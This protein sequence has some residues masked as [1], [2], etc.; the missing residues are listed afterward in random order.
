MIFEERKAGVLLPVFSLPSAYGIGTFGTQAYR[1]VDLLH[2]AKQ[3]Y[4]QVLPQGAT[5]YRDSPYQ[6]F[7][8]F[9]GNPYFIDL[10]L[11][12]EKGVITKADCDS[13]F[14]GDDEN[15]ID[16]KAMY[17]NRYKLLRIA[18]AND[19][20]RQSKEYIEFK[21]QSDFWLSDYA[22][23][24]AVK[25][26]NNGSPWYLWQ[27]AERLKQPFCMENLHRELSE[28]IEFYKYLQYLF[29]AQWRALKSYANQKGIQIIGDIPIYVALDSADVWADKNLF[30][31]DD[32]GLPTMVAGCPP[33]GFSATGQLWGNPLYNWQQHQ[34]TNFAWWIKRVEQTFQMYDVVRIDH[35]RGF[36][37][38]YA[39]PFGNS[40]AEKGIW[41]KAEG[42]Q[43]FD[44]VNRRLGNVKIIAEDLG[45]ITESVRKLLRQTGYPGMKVMQFAFSKDYESSYLLHNHIKNCV[46]YTG[47]HDNQT[48]KGWFYSLSTEDRNYAAQYMGFCDENWSADKFLKHTLSSC[49]NL[50][51][52]PMQD[53]LDIGNEGRINTPSTIEKNWRWRMSKTLFTQETAEYMANLAK[54]Y[55]RI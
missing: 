54:L 39:I 27:D 29:F 40:T 55:Y 50:V 6:S 23:F 8:T 46:V 24:M 42:Q 47:T 43:L 52:I 49:A 36:D 37:E 11:L 17:E 13:L 1:F 14:F 38:F 32:N 28:D 20:S 44:T 2:Q 26:K 53:Y 18:F 12:I 35:F 34:N 45:H 10:E 19:C 41:L 5:S 4:W 51:I 22:L 31:L 15:Y 16:Y 7:S 30:M 33:D 25:D 21:E 9:A 3:S 48:S